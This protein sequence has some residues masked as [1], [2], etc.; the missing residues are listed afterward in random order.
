MAKKNDTKKIVEQ[1]EAVPE[2][3]EAYSAE[4]EFGDTVD[5]DKTP[6]VSGE[7]KEI[8]TVEFGKGRSAK[9]SRVMTLITE[10]GLKSVWESA[11][12]KGLFDEA[13]AGWNILIR[14]VGRVKVKGRK[15]EMK[16]YRVF[17]KGGVPAKTKGKK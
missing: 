13:E 6:E 4:S 10:T 2:G 11:K 3:Y 17:I 12:L 14:F 1:F 5:F 16:D 8:K 7:V 9:E 15:E